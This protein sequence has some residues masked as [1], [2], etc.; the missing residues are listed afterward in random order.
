[1]AGASEPTIASAPVVSAFSNAA[2]AADMHIRLVKAEVEEQWGGET[3][4][5]HGEA[6]SRSASLVNNSACLHKTFYML[7]TVHMLPQALNQK[8]CIV[9]GKCAAALACDAAKEKLLQP[10]WH[11]ALGL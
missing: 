6:C 5:Q 11:Y 9:D 1:L 2:P 7:N 4:D 8:Y 3:A 10:Y